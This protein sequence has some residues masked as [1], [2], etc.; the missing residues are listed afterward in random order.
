[1]MKNSPRGPIPVIMAIIVVIIGSVALYIFY[2]E[3]TQL[4]E[5][6]QTLQ[7]SIQVYLV[8]SLF[9]FQGGGF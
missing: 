7:I 8:L 1:M 6:Q 4:L 2:Q 5:Q 3:K 9:I